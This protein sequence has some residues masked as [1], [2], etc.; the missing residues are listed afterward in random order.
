[1]D[2]KNFDGPAWCGFFLVIAL[3]IACAVGW[4]TNI[5]KLFFY[6]GSGF[7]G[8]FALRIVGIFVAPLGV[9][10]GYL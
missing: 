4:I 10:L 6:D 5:V 8:E 1:M 9:V 7:T 3:W 2:T